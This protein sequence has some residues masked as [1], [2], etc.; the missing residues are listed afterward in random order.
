MKKTIIYIVAFAT[1]S[2]GYS[3]NTENEELIEQ[4]QKKINF[5]IDLI[6]AY[7]EQIEEEIKDLRK[8]NGTK[9]HVSNKLKKE[10]KETL[11]KPTGA[12]FEAIVGITDNEGIGYHGNFSF[13]INTKKKNGVEMGLLYDS[14]DVLTDDTKI[15]S[16]VFIL[17]LGYTKQLN[18]LSNKTETISSRF[19][20]GGA[21]GTEI[22]NDS[23]ENLENGTILTTEGGLIYGGYV[24]LFSLFKIS[25]RFSA[26]FRNSH[27]FTTSNVSIHKFI[28][29]AGLRYNF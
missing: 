2:I 29:G 27:F 19:V 5:Q 12:S 1:T 14:N 3:Q 7:N 24:G 18:F 13:E 25:N 26:V 28:V 6:E 20:I 10:P 23:K 11:K 4:I 16:E 21:A 15:T 22:L 17:N 9:M 8:Q